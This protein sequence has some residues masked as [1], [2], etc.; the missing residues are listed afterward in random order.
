MVGFVRFNS[1][2]RRYQI[3][4]G[5]PRGQGVQPRAEQPGVTHGA[6][7]GRCLGRDRGENRTLPVPGV[8]ENFL[9]VGV[10]EPVGDEAFEGGDV[11]RATGGAG[12]GDE[13]LVGSGVGSE[14]SFAFAVSP[15]PGE[16]VGVGA[17][18]AWTSW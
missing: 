15:G 8:G 12:I 13:G 6:V 16:G 17:G 1:S 9:D 7:P 4:Q 2:N 5:Q 11:N 3:R 14:G 18:Q 10:F